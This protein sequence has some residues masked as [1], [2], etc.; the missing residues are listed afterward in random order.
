MDDTL[1]YHHTEFN[2]RI[3]TLNIELENIIN[4]IDLN[5]LKLSQ[6]FR[7]LSSEGITLILGNLLII[8]FNGE[9]VD[10]SRKK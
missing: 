7:W 5:P 9:T 3:R 4:W 10:Q 6:I 1:L 2:C 8:S